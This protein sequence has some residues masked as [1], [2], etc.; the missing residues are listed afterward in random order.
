MK[1]LFAKWLEFETTYGTEEQQGLVR[2]AA[3]KYLNTKLAE[4]ETVHDK[5]QEIKSRS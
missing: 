1:P 3:L 4:D 5:I 2:A